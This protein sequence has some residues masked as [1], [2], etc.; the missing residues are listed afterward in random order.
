MIFY[1]QLLNIQQR[2]VA[3]NYVVCEST[4][5]RVVGY[6]DIASKN[7]PIQVEG[8]MPNN[9]FLGINDVGE[10]G[11]YT[12]DLTPEK[13]QK[14]N[15]EGN[16]VSKVECFADSSV[17]VLGWSK[18]ETITPFDLLGQPIGINKQV[19][20]IESGV[21]K[22]VDVNGTIIP[23]DSDL[24]I[25][26]LV[27][28]GSI[29]DN[30]EY[31]ISTKKG[32]RVNTK[33]STPELDLW[34][35]KPII[36]CNGIL[37]TKNQVLTIKDID[38]GSCE[39][40]DIDKYI[41]S[42]NIDVSNDSAETQNTETKIISL[43]EDVFIQK[44]TA[45]EKVISPEQIE[46]D[47]FIVSWGSV[48]CPVLQLAKKRAGDSIPTDNISPSI[49]IQSEVNGEHI[50]GTLN[51]VIACRANGEVYWADISIINPPTPHGLT[52]GLNI[53][54]DKLVEGII[55]T[56]HD[57]IELENIKM[58][59]G[60]PRFFIGADFG[61][62]ANPA[63]L[64][65]KANSGVLEWLNV[66]GGSHLNPLFRAGVNINPIDFLNGQISVD[67]F[68]TM[69]GIHLNG[70]GAGYSG[71]VLELNNNVGIRQGKIQCSPIDDLNT[72]PITEWVEPIV[73][74]FWTATAS[75]LRIDLN[76]INDAKSATDIVVANTMTIEDAGSQFHFLES[77]NAVN[78]KR[79]LKQNI[80]FPIG[81]ISPLQ[82]YANYTL[83]RT[84]PSDNAI[85]VGSLNIV[86]GS[87]GTADN[88]AC[89]QMYPSLNVVGFHIGSGLNAM[90]IPTGETIPCSTMD[91]QLIY[92]GVVIN[93][94]NVI[95]CNATIYARLGYLKDHQSW[96]SL[97]YAT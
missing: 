12:M 37:G 47:K 15:G 89:I 75:G 81:L 1:Q 39:W 32:I 70:S 73:N 91:I 33:V 23:T 41:G 49:T 14:T 42:L 9:T 30:D 66:T 88:T 61:S 84:K 28:V 10:F 38:N 21:M 54:G 79:Y 67:Y 77:S 83:I 31:S 29:P 78:G 51:Q 35:S 72:T 2:G 65:C 56:K 27:V 7:T 68:P 92:S 40:A 80:T 36:R 3:I 48:Y 34:S 95:Y 6:L 43:K 87:Q 69:A 19:L 50:H 24:T 96:S 97:L 46:S 11:Y 93:G 5:I 53:D 44:L 26:S 13:I 20:G 86:V 57:L 58:N 52:A 64:G 45:T 25:N 62:R 17:S 55:A 60:T 74:V 82:L 22:W 59:A 8:N 90:G 4:H 18:F 71:A 16:V 76:T 94:K 85:L 63:V